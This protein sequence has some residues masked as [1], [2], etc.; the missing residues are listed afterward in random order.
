M[1]RH[2][3]AMI[4]PNTVLSGARQRLP[5]PKRSGQSMSRSELADAINAALDRIYLGRDVTAHYVDFRWVGKLERGEH[6]W[7]SAARRAAL[8]Q[9]LGTATDTDLDL[10]SPRRTDSKQVAGNPSHPQ[11]GSWDETIYLL[12]GQWH[13]LVQND[14]ILGPEY[15]LVGVTSQLTVIGGFLRDVPQAL[16]PAL[17][18]LAAQYAESAAWLNQSL[19]DYSAGHH[20]TRKALNWSDQ[21]ADP[22]MT[23]WATY[24]GSQQWLTSGDPVRALEQAEAALRYDQK[25]PGPMRAALRVQHAHALAANGRHREALR[26]LDEAHRWAADRHPGKPEGEHGSYC[27]S[28]Y[29]EV[30]RG[31]CLQLAQRPHEAIT[32]LDDALPMIPPLHRQDFAS[33]LLN[34]ATAHAAASQPDLAAATAHTALPIA[35]RAG[36]R[37]LVQQLAQLG[38]AVSG[39][40]HLPDVRAF[41]EDLKETA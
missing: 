15:A 22:A 3:D 14:K 35:R 20:W 6:R 4:T 29:I 21:V 1:P 33:A 32:V 7:P 17:V 16:R 5:S 26:L 31:A 36:S 25:L 23:A 10:Y 9:V 30:H 40:R 34:K 11:P 2:P 39:H 18:R 8:R 12:R 24:R 28:G 27:T 19:N 13:L 41:L 37:R 38:T